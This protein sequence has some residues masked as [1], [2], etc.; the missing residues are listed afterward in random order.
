MEMEAIQQVRDRLN[1]ALAAR[2]LVALSRC[3]APDYMVIT[4]VNLR[5]VGWA[6]NV[7]RLA[8][9]L[10][11]KRDLEQFSEARMIRVYEPWGMAHEEGRWRAAWSAPDGAITMAGTYAA[12]WQKYEDAGWLIES[13]LLVP[14]HCTGGAYCQFALPRVRS[15]RPDAGPMDGIQG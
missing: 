13:E 8:M 12:K 15:R 2:D 1:A 9:E 4:S 10:L 5:A 7:D 14:S 3:W 11:V 6:V